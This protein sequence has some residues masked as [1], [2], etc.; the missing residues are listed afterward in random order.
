[1]PGVHVVMLKA[2]GAPK[3]PGKVLVQ[4]TEGDPVKVSVVFSVDWWGQQ[5]WQANCTLHGRPIECTLTPS[6]QA[7]QTL[8]ASADAHLYHICD[9]AP[10]V[11]NAS[12]TRVV[13]FSMESDAN[14][15]CIDQ[16]KA[17]LEMTYRACSQV[18]FAMFVLPACSM[19]E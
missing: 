17:D 7:S 10:V 13:R 1:M 5:S 15:P 4:G 16:Q 6:V 18:Y 19:L 8:L 11:A 9:G 14:Q 2:F 3:Q 12:T